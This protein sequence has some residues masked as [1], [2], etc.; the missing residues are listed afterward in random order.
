M[1]HD[2]ARKE[3]LNGV[4][5][6]FFK[7]EDIEVVPVST[8]SLLFPI[9]D[10]EFVEEDFMEQF[11]FIPTDKEKQIRMRAEKAFAERGHIQTETRRKEPE[12]LPVD[13]DEALY[14]FA[15]EAILAKKKMKPSKDGPVCS[16]FLL[17]WR[18]YSNPT[19]KSVYD[20]S[21]SL[22]LWCK[23]Q[24]WQARNL[25]YLASQPPERHDFL[26]NRL[27]LNYFTYNT[28]TT[29]RKKKKKKTTKTTKKKSSSYNLRK[30]AKCRKSNNKSNR[31]HN[32]HSTPKKHTTPTKRKRTNTS[33]TKKTPPRRNNGTSTTPTKRRRTDGQGRETTTQAE[34]ASSEMMA[35]LQHLIIPRQNKDRFPTPSS[36]RRRLLQSTLLELWGQPPVNRSRHPS[37]DSF[38]DLMDDDMPIDLDESS[39]TD[40]NGMP[41]EVSI[42]DVSPSS[43]E[44]LSSS[45]SSCEM[46]A[47]P[48][49]ATPINQT[50]PNNPSLQHIKVMYVGE[51]VT[52]TAWQGTIDSLLESTLLSSPPPPPSINSNHP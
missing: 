19:W 22:Q 2:K 24:D 41:A 42:E 5:G 16:H 11:L 28:P 26:K 8:A 6:I 9:E 29:Y 27:D 47:S 30:R 20:L 49:V 15:V 3:G 46:I 13:A 18:R 36:E 21:P 38:I 35:E 45:S 1:I 4:T 50:V 51:V 40:L 52:I 17:K 31:S 23:A 12:Y 14:D 39:Y 7:N 10:G 43:M 44:S 34:S 25:R 37:A 33:A 48:S 32:S